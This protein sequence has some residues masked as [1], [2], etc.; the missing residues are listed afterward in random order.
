[1]VRVGD[2]A[3]LAARKAHGIHADIGKGHTHE[4]HRLALANGEQHVHLTTRMNLRD[5]VRQ[6]NEVVG[7]LAHG[8]NDRDDVVSLSAGVG[9][10]LGDGPHAVGVGH[11]GAAVLLNNEGHECE[12]L[13]GRARTRKMNSPRCGRATHGR[14]ASS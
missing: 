2:D 7:F 14:A 11:A 3:H 12:I 9:D 10:V 4:R 1:V 13:R 8:G 5:L 6:R